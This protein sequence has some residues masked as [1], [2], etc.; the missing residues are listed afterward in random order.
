MR[1][2]RLAPVVALSFFLAASCSGDAKPAASSQS[3]SPLAVASS[4]TDSSGTSVG[5]KDHPVGVLALGH[6]A[7]TGESSDP[8]NPG[9]TAYQ[10][11]WATGTAPEVASVYLRLVAARPETQGQV[12]NEAEGGAIASKLAPQA[13]AGL[14]A[15]PFPQ[16]VIIQTIDNDIRCDAA[17]VPAFGASVAD[18]L[19]SIT[20]KSPNSVILMVDQPGRPIDD[21]DAVAQVPDAKAKATGSGPCDPFNPAGEKVDANIA[22]LT[23]TIEKYE[24]EQARVCATFPQC[25]TDGGVFVSFKGWFADVVV[26]DWNHLNVHGLAHI[27]E[28]AWPVVERLLHLS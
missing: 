6:S 18:A 20:D 19:K 10:N 1:S 2:T 23:A 22:R 17:N 11:S 28:T 21:V 25:H 26:D 7:L 13:N 14:R 3:T 4:A 27:A 5:T 9:R 15:L 12:D 8:T 24:A 16:L